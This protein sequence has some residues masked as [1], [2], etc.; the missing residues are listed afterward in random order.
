MSES[1]GLKSAISSLDKAI[2][3]TILYFELVPSSDLPK[4]LKAFAELRDNKKRLEELL[5]SLTLLYTTLDNKVLPDAFEALGF[6]SVKSA[7]KNFI[8]STRV[9]ANITEDK[10]A[11]AHKW[12]SEEANVPELIQPRINPKQLSSFAVEYFETN[13]KWPPENLISIHKQNYIQVRK[14]T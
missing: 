11:D 8:L 9:N 6:D 7:G 5:K 13:G 4:L 14:A 12:I 2:T 3:D 10:R 1:V